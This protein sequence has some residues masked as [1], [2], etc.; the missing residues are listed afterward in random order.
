ML[1]LYPNFLW[2]L[3][4]IAIPI[5]VHLF[6]FRIHKTV[7]FSNIKFLENLK[8]QNKSKSRLKQILI[9][10]SRILF[11]IS[12][13]LAFSFPY[14]DKNKDLKNTKEKI[15][16]IYI[17]N[18]F[19]MNAES[20]YGNIFDAAKERA[21]S[22]INSYDNSQK[23][24]FLNNQFEAKYRNITNKKQILKFV[25]ETDLSAKRN[26]LSKIIEYQ[27][28]F[29]NSEFKNNDFFNSIFIISDFQKN[30]S[31]FENIKTDS[32]QIINLI[33]LA[34]SKINNIYID[35]IWFDSPER[36]F[37]KVETLN[38][39][40]A[41]SGDENYKDIP[42]KLLINNK[43][44]AISNF[45]IE[46]KSEKTIKIN[47]TNTEKGIL[48]CKLEIKDYPISFDNSFYFNYKIINKINILLIGSRNENKFIKTLFNNNDD[49][50]LDYS[51]FDNIKNSELPNY[52]LI[53]LDELEYLSSGFIQLIKDFVV[54]GGNL[55]FIPNINGDIQNYN[56]LL[57]NINTEKF[58][59]IDTS[60]TQIGT[61]EYEHFIYK[62]VF[63]KQNK[64][65][66]L[67]YI[68][69]HF[70]KGNKL[71]NNE[72][73]ILKSINDVTL[74][75]YVNLKNSNVYIL[76]FAINKNNS[77]FVLHP[78]F[79]PTLYNIAAFSTQNNKLYYTIAKEKNIILNEKTKSG[80]QILH[81]K[82]LDNSFNFIPNTTNTN[83][84][85]KLSKLDAIKKAE[86]YILTN[87]G[88][89]VCG[90]SFN[91][92]RK[93]SEIDY[94]NIDE[95]KTLIEDNKLKN[96]EIL[97]A[98]LDNLNSE[99]NEIK[100]ERKDLWKIFIVLALVFLIFEILLI[101][102]WKN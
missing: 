97:S 1:F 42:I 16:S 68:K 24:I 85:I 102:L 25:N 48:K 74:L 40:I 26:S 51:N 39:K 63:D 41:N 31:D 37:N 64:K 6:S 60:D 76:S 88:D 54:N 23:F 82:N 67:P 12:L 70:K 50:S 69:N 98:K 101:K 96:T 35:S 62:D 66:L 73:S 57:S 34:S 7:Y 18:S 59:D 20:E 91:Y 15:V 89:T 65:L 84:N 3:F 27:L 28:Q 29:L 83:N 38:V 43:Q 94:Y 55:L 58:I 95:I 75:S 13:V 47:F 86:N 80:E 32:N 77:N 11:I 2:A 92:N 22:I 9:L 5:I 56:E 44:K 79:V 72:K 100:N 33:P 36:R 78:L 87:N 10:I 17:D 21:K 52:Q 30:I 14:I 46:E 81:I 99:M 4:F 8:N 93:E 90:L 49:F 71:L 45:N 61:I 53:I 19:S